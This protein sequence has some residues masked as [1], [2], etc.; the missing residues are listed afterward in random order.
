M[1]YND[2]LL[3]TFKLTTMRFSVWCERLKRLVTLPSF[4]TEMSSISARAIDIWANFPPNVRND[5]CFKSFRA[6]YGKTANTCKHISFALWKFKSQMNL[7]QTSKLQ[8]QITLCLVA[9][10]IQHCKRP[11]LIGKTSCM[12]YSSFYG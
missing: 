6:Q 5:H 8:R 1:N 11:A 2:S 4:Y 12:A 10:N 3:A 9:K 7:F